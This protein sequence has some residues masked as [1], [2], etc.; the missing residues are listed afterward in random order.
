MTPEFSDPV[1]DATGAFKRRARDLPING[2]IG[3]I[4]I[5]AEMFNKIGWPTIILMLAVGITLGYVRHP[6]QSLIDSVNAH[7]EK[8]VGRDQTLKTL[9]E[10]NRILSENLT[11]QLRWTQ[12]RLCSEI[13]DTYMRNACLQ[14][15]P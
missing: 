13:R 2:L 7:E 11:K 8:A 1:S 10:S 3:R 6:L 14:E 9:A 5:I 12:M 4:L 15:K